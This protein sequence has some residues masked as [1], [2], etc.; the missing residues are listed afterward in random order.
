[1]AD[2]DSQQYT[3]VG[4]CGN[5]DSWWS[6][7]W[8]NNKNFHLTALQ[9]QYRLSCTSVKCINMLLMSKTKFCINIL[10]HL[11]N[12]NNRALII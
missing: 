2:P 8:E 7:W 5:S 1:M 3:N 12:P 10:I 6:S 11:S 4:H 9:I